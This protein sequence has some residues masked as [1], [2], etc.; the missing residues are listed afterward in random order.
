MIN[1]ELYQ[2]YVR[3]FLGFMSPDQQN[4]VV[5]TDAGLEYKGNLIVAIKGLKEK[6]TLKEEHVNKVDD[7]INET[8]EEKTEEV[9]KVRRTRKN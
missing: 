1:Q 4:E 9:K 7:S 8:V 2:H 3:K 6:L 5:V